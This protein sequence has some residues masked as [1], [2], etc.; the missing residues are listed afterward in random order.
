[1]DIIT[2]ILMKVTIKSPV[3]AALGM[4]LLLMIPVTLPAM[5]FTL[6]TAQAAAAKGDPQAEYFLGKQYAHGNGVPQDYT[7]AAEYFRQAATQGYAFAENDLGALYAKGL[8]VKQDDQEASQCYRRAAE[9]GDSLAQFNLGREYALGHGVPKDMAQALNWYQ[10]AAEQNQPGS[11][12]ALGDIYFI[13][14]QGI[15][16]DYVAA[17]KYYS[18]AVVQGRLDCLNNLGLAYERGGANKNPALAVKC[19]REAVAQGDG[20]AMMNLGRMYEYGTGVEK[21][22]VEAYKWYTLAL[23]HGVLLARR[24]QQTLDGTSPISH[25]RLTPDQIAEA[26]RRADQYVQAAAKVPA[27]EN[28]AATP[29]K[30]A[31]R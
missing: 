27:L 11:L 2:T 14:D 26:T 29:E 3:S 1:M 22:P 9:Q 7:K 18:N 12:A 20:R 19:F 8:G 6:D 5:E 17:L 21:D 23:H 28:G 25:L 13:G 10:K 24:F 31:V 16:V 30:S 4:A 15:K